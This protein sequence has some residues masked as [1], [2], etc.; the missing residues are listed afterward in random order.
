[1]SKDR[2]S[3]SILCSFEILI[4]LLA[5]L[6]GLALQILAVIHLVVS[7]DKQVIILLVA[8][9]HFFHSQHRGAFYAGTFRILFR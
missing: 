7:K 9:R 1:M 2:V 3:L 5:M 8:V 4:R 6:V